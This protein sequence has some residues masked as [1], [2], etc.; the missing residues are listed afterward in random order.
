MFIKNTITYLIFMQYV[1]TW[2]CVVR[3]RRRVVCAARGTQP[4][5]CKDN[6]ERWPNLRLRF[7]DR[8]LKIHTCRSVKSSLFP[9]Q[10]NFSAELQLHTGKIMRNSLPLSVRKR[11]S[12]SFSEI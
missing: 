2:L 5:V 3:G 9:L 10:F 7:A 1:R 12:Y 8:M 11:A 6:A 4:A